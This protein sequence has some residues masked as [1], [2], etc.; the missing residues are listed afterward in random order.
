M[1]INIGNWTSEALK[2]IFLL[3]CH[4]CPMVIYIPIFFIGLQAFSQTSRKLPFLTGPT[5]V[6][7]IDISGRLLVCSFATPLMER[8]LSLSP[9]VLQA[10]TSRA[11]ELEKVTYASMEPIAH[12]GIR[13]KPTTFLHNLVLSPILWWKLMACQ[14]PVPGY[15]THNG[16]N[17]KRLRFQHYCS[18]FTSHL[19]TAQKQT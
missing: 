16:N 13:F 9:A 3:S 17:I 12:R 4:R 19:T 6:P 7:C 15:I 14:S 5:R 2:T 18:E 11:W 8:A 10:T 1:P